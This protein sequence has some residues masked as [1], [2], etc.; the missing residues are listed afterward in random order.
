MSREKKLAKS[1]AI[2]FI[3]SFGSKLLSFILLPVYSNY[4]TTESYGSY[5]L[6]HT[7]IQIVYP[8]MTFM[9][10]NAIYVYVIGTED[11]KKKADIIS[12]AVR[13]LAVNCSITIVLCLL[14]NCIYPIQYIGWV[15]YWLIS[16][17]VY[18]TW[19]QVC[20]SLYQ[21]KLYSLTGVI[22]TAVIL[23]GN[24]IGLVVLRQDY[25]FLMVSNCLANTIAIIFLESRLH[26]MKYVL[27]GHASIKLK[28]ELLKYAAPLLPNQLSWWVLNVS[29]RLMI[30]YY[31]GTG[32]NGIYA[33]ACK[34]PG[35]LNIVHGIFAAAWSDDILTSADI[36]ETEKYAEKIYNKY[37]RLMIGIAVILMSA[38][39]LLFTY[40]ISGNFVE[41]YK[42]TYFLYIGFI[43]GSLGS[44]LGAFYGFYKKSLNVSLSTIAAALI[45]FIINFIFM[46]NYG[47]EVASISTCIG[48]LAIWIVRLLGLKGQV[49]I[50]IYGMTK[51]M[52]LLLVPFYFLADMEGMM[53]NA[54][55]IA[56]GVT[57]AVLIN[58][59]SMKEVTG[60]LCR[61]LNRMKG[62]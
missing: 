37:I 57:I 31:L 36:R 46:K 1:V 23:I 9:L 32:A 30:T 2:Y 8:L 14:L 38:N 58:L 48:S 44:L 59:N 28:K 3:G 41:A 62:K 34:I 20:R 21:Q 18:S 52:F 40:I 17:S 50:K 13:I 22:V 12:F 47:I 15:I 25:K 60:A 7:V 19:I 6:I 61:K 49:K 45:N 10:D 26:V 43:F 35:V 51:L 53:I 27:N 24:I 33:M 54:L 56:V 16:Y 39:K 4:L 55:L 5:D 11:K 29:D 42:Y